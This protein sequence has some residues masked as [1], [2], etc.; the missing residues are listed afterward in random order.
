MSCRQHAPENS[1]AIHVHRVSGKWTVSYLHTK[2]SK[3][4]IF[5]TCGNADYYRH[6][7]QATAV[8]I[9]CHKAVAEI[10]LFI[11]S[12]I[13]RSSGCTWLHAHIRQP[14]MPVSAHQCMAAAWCEGAEQ[15]QRSVDLI[16]NLQQCWSSSLLARAK[17]C[18]TVSRMDH[19]LIAA[20]VGPL[21]SRC[22][23]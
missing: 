10:W 21:P 4:E 11:C 8:L 12:T 22:R 3:L 15:Q 17:H 18:A 19:C 9:T 23:R 14:R 2:H 1:L 6:S 20:K 5:A 7:R 13:R 16:W